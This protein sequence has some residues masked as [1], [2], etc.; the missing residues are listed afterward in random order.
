MA[1]NQAQV[2]HIISTASADDPE[3][4]LLKLQD[5]VTLI[6]TSIKK[7]LI[8]IRERMNDLENPIIIAPGSGQDANVSGSMANILKNTS[9]AVESAAGAVKAGTEMQRSEE[10][11]PEGHPGITAAVGAP[12][13]NTPHNAEPISKPSQMGFEGG[14]D[15]LSAFKSQIAGLPEKEAREEI[16]SDKVRLQKVFRLFEWTSKN[17]NRF[18]HDRVDLMLDAYNAMGHITETS[19]KLVKDMTRLMPANIGEDHEIKADEFVSELYELNHILNPSDA[20]LDRDMI[21]VLMEKRQDKESRK[22]LTS[23]RSEEEELEREYIRTRD[24]A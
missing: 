6:K 20:T 10:P 14:M 15:L 7:L 24:R 17:V 5:E 8:D 18:G 11:R 13:V 19:C 23:P 4:K 3:V 22:L 1:V 16:L 21:E 12:A 9:S 2:D